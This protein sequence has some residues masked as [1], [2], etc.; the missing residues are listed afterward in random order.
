MAE[1][2]KRYLYSLMKL[3]DGLHAIVITDRD[4]VPVI[5]VA[6]ENAPELA[7]RPNFLSTF[8]LTTEQA[9]KL[10]LAKNKSVVC[11]YASYQVVQIN[12]LPF[13]IT[14]VAKSDANTGMLLSL[15][16]ELKESLQ[17]LREVLTVP[18][19]LS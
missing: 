14:L 6:G 1:E 5:K 11:M 4:G 19:G 8:G 12:K 9:G 16:K 13:L 15:E 18:Q 2:L 3:V 7:L 17:D 10:G